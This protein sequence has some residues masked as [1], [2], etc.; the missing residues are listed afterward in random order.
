MAEQLLAAIALLFAVAALFIAGARLSGRLRGP[1][2]WTAFATEFVTVAA[3]VLP[4]WLGGVW[5]GLAALALALGCA[6]ELY[7]VLQKSGDRPRLRV[8]LALNAA[9]VAL[10]I[11][12]PQYLL[13]ALFSSS[14][15]LALLWVGPG[16]GTAR[17][18]SLAST[19]T[20]AIY[21]GLCAGCAAALALREGGFGYAVFAFALVEIND[22]A[23]YLVGASFGK[24][25]LIPMLSP[26]KTLAGSVAGAVAALA[27][28]VGFAF[29]VP[30]WSAAERIGASVLL[31]IA[32]P[33]GD[34]LASTF[35]RRAGVKDFGNSVPIAGGILDVY[36]SFL[37]VSPL[38]HVYLAALSS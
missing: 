3:V 34:L 27:A 24:R 33:A 16:A 30:D 35:K 7:A 19:L 29:L 21:P 10:G 18:R 4:A 5:V 8:G 22:S 26:N 25:K 11:A 20:G 23:A 2:V 1:R 36:D 13:P 28:G 17:S 32:G 38:L 9:A 12:A 6:R 37:L 31:A 15:A 14:L